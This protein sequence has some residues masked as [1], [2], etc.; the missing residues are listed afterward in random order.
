MQQKQQQ[1]QQSSSQQ[2][3]QQLQGHFGNFFENAWPHVAQPHLASNGRIPPMAATLLVR[4]RVNCSVNYDLVSRVYDTFE[5]QFED[6][7]HFE[8]AVEHPVSYCLERELHGIFLKI[9]GAKVLSR[10]VSLTFIINSK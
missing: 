8:S 7:P 5:K 2:Q 6:D 10:L 4:F 3:P 9:I 1:K